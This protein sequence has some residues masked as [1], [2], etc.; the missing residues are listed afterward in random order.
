[1]SAEPLCNSQT[2]TPST[3]T[4]QTRRLLKSL[5][6]FGRMLTSTPLREQASKQSITHRTTHSCYPLLLVAVLVST[7]V[8]SHVPRTLKR[9]CF[10][11]R[12]VCGPMRRW[13]MRVRLITC[14]VGGALVAVLLRFRRL[15][16]ARR[17]LQLLLLLRANARVKGTSRDNALAGSDATGRQVYVHHHLQAGTI[18]RACGRSSDS[19][20]AGRKC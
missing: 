20:P 9:L 1:M 15:R 4:L 5:Q 11:F 12:T 8:C 13:L 17:L 10:P 7:A 16:C 3:R 2:K 6:T 14:A 18:G 19:I